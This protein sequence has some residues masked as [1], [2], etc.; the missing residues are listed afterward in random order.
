MAGLAP[1]VLTCAK[2]QQDPAALA[3]LHAVVPQVVASLQAVVKRCSLPRMFSLVLT[4]I[5]SK[6]NALLQ[7][8]GCSCRVQ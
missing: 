3:I 5:R 4:G 2:D 6:L 8:P 1:H 7:L